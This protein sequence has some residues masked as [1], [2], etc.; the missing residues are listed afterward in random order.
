MNAFAVLAT[1]KERRKSLSVSHLLIA[2]LR[3]TEK[4]KQ[5]TRNRRVDLPVSTGSE[6]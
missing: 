1:I 2:E 3:L 5:K 6:N 4:M